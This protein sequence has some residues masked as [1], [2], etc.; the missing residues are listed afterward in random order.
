MQGKVFLGTY[1][2]QKPRKYI[3]GS[4]DRFDKF[5]DRIRI[6][7]DG[8]YLFVKNYYPQ[9]APYK[10]IEYRK[11]MNLMNELLTL[12][13]GGKLTGSNAL[14]FRPTKTDEE[15]YDCQTDPFNMNNRID[16]PQCS[17]K[18]NELRGALNQYINDIHDKAIIPEAKMVEQMWP[19]NQQP[20][21][22]QPTVSVKNGL[23]QLSCTNSAA[24]IGYILSVTKIKPTIND[25]WQLYNTPIKAGNAKFIYVIADRIG[26][27]DSEITK[28]E[29]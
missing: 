4:S 29:L 20:K 26:F 12:R 13:D 14:W 27:S 9:L 2:S 10:D 7:R 16:D 23:I 17:S 1:K 24:S 28:K 25:S 3:F 22:A 11:Q 18:I 6:I 8:R 5:S 21:T 15:F 19:G